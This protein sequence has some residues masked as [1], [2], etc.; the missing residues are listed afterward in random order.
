VSRLFFL[1][2]VAVLLG[3]ATG[4]T[5]FISP[6]TCT[7]A[8]DTQPDSKCASLCV[9]CACSA[10]PIVPAAAFLLSSREL[11]A[12]PADAP[13]HAIALGSPHDILHVP[14]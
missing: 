12:Q 14:K 5:A 9:R 4:L 2:I 1:A 3:D 11:C 6:E 13:P 8:T 7:A 10:T